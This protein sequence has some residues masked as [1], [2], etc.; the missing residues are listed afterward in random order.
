MLTEDQ[1]LMMEKH[2][3][4][5]PSQGIGIYGLNLYGE[6]EAFRRV[7]DSIHKSRCAN[8][9]WLNSPEA[10]MY[11]MQKGVNMGIDPLTAL[12]ELKMVKGNWTISIKLARGQAARKGITWF[13][14][15]KE[16]ECQITMKREGW[17][18]HIET[19]T[20]ADIKKSG[21]GGPKDDAFTK[22]PRQIL[23]SS[24]FRRGINA[25][26]P[27]VLMGLDP[28]DREVEPDDLFN[29]P[30]ETD[31]VEPS[32]V[33]AKDV[34]PK[35]TTKKKTSKK[36][37]PKEEDKKAVFVPPEDASE[38]KPI[39]MTFDNM[40]KVW[41]RNADGKEVNEHGVEVFLYKKSWKTQEEIDKL[42][43]KNKPSVAEVT[44][45]DASESF[46][47]FK[48]P[49]PA[50]EPVLVSYDP[51]DTEHLKVMIDAMTELQLTGDQKKYIKQNFIEFTAKNPLALD[52]NACKGAMLECL[53]S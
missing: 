21:R 2:R 26:G 20:T 38:D 50:E 33:S 51:D 23:R 40:R 17:N 28:V 46:D 49:T 37:A 10:V 34:K 30:N 43:A 13:F 12:E 29:S 41:V 42:E 39:G 36:A 11:V 4:T 22:F 32:E 8:Q 31:S 25:I 14:S 24:A 18:D 35:K 45:E 52:L 15:E 19:V 5:A 27:D 6:Y 47:E 1:R 16:S 48:K 9:P 53:K 3:M 7:A 44:P